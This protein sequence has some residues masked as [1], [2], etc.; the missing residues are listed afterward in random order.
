MY[1]I[2]CGREVTDGALFCQSC[3]NTGGETKPHIPEAK[4]P[5]RKP[6]TPVV[7][8][9]PQKKQEPKKKLNP[10]LIPL[11]ALCLLTVVSL[12]AVYYFYNTMNVIK[13]NYRVKE[14]NLTVQLNERDSLQEALTA[15][16][17]ELALSQALVQTQ[18]DT[19]TELQNQITQ[20]EG[21]ASQEI[22]DSASAQQT[23]DRL[24]EEKTG[25]STQLSE[26][27]QEH[28]TL[29]ADME[30]LQETLT[31]TE[32]TLEE[33]EAALEKASEKAEFMDSYVVFV[34]ND[35]TDYYHTY[36]CRNFKKSNFWA[37]SRKLA[38]S[39]GYEA[40]PHCGG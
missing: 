1:C 21:N 24:T 38:E 22:Y 25:L 9:I 14:A 34:N 28:E 15:T 5:E 12:V 27:E 3:S 23:I 16:E 20:L 18:S 32:Q 30:A 19:I 13:N 7:R 11:I 6:D 37:Y 8:N 35:D 40:C 26:L 36:D 4:Q 33:T 39:Y 31:E 2:K 17:Q 29:T 10:L